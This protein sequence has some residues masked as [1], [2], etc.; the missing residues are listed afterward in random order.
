MKSR[1]QLIGRIGEHIAYQFLKQKGQVTFDLEFDFKLGKK[2]V[3]TKTTLEHHATNYSY[4]MQ[5]ET[6]G[7]FVCRIPHHFRLCEQQ[8][9]YCFVLLRD[10][11]YSS[12]RLVEA[13]KVTQF[14]KTSG[15]IWITWPHI[16]QHRRVNRRKQCT[17]P[18]FVEWKSL[19]E[20]TMICRW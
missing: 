5:K 20:P 10:D 19:L 1:G 13:S 12:V 15:M 16:F 2:A 8:G 11:G 3:E 6:T 14:Y 7:Y 18:P 17:D 4:S 9:M